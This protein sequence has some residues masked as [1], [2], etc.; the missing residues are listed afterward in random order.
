MIVETEIDLMCDRLDRFHI[1]TNGDNISSIIKKGCMTYTDLTHMNIPKKTILAARKELKNNHKLAKH[2]EQAKTDFLRIG[3]FSLNKQGLLYYLD[4]AVVPK[5][6][7]NEIIR[8]YFDDPATT[9]EREHLHERLSRKFIGIGRRAVASFIKSQQVSQLKKHT[10]RSDLGRGI[11]MGNF[12]SHIVE[13]DLVF[14]EK[15]DK[16][17]NSNHRYICTML[18]RFSG[19]VGACPLRR[20]DAKLVLECIQKVLK[21]WKKYIM[22]VLASD[23][24]ME[25]EGAVKNVC[26][27]NNIK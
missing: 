25:F 22:V 15:A 12:P 1:S 4:R 3:G 18:D 24:D 19:K 11:S 5:E 17:L 10:M 8:K 14:M 6:I 7:V 23:N 2:P 9:G 26:K 27:K 20:K 13:I 16:T 21:E